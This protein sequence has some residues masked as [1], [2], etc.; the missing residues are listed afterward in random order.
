TPLLADP[1]RTKT[2]ADRLEP[3]A[4]TVGA[5]VMSDTLSLVVFAMCV[6]TFQRGFSWSGLALQLAEVVRFIPLLLFGVGRG[7]RVLL[8]KVEDDENAYFILMFGT[9]AVAAVL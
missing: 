5:T 3:I 9:M 1:I 4:V 7:G 8:N 2:G 6:S